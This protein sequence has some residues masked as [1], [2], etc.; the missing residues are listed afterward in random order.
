MMMGFHTKHHKFIVDDHEGLEHLNNRMI[1]KV[2]PR[3]VVMIDQVE[4]EALQCLA[5]VS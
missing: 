5:T 4:V 2:S 3:E 1:F